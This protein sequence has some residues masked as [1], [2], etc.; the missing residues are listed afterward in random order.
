MV[1]IILIPRGQH[2]GFSGILTFKS[3]NF[4]LNFR[5]VDTLEEKPENILG[6]GLFAGKG[7]DFGFN[8]R[9]PR[10]AVNLRVF[11]ARKKC[12]KFCSI[13]VSIVTYEANVLREK[14]I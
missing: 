11:F 13:L 1:Y 4:L 14:K 9:S 3:R 8:H 5:V 7:V 12:H 6:H 2:L 10:E